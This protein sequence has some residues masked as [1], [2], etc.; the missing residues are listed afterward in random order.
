M[1]LP[2]TEQSGAAR[3]KA[4]A[5][6]WRSRRSIQLVL[7]LLFASVV[8]L[9]PFS[10]LLRFTVRLLCLEDDYPADWRLTLSPLSS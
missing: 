10:R 5:A 4:P 6:A 1:A 7:L 8:F 3:T 9:W 2:L